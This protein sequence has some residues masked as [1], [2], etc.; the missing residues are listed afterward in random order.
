MRVIVVCCF[1]VIVACGGEKEQPAPQAREGARDAAAPPPPSLAGPLTVDALL[2][3]KRGVKP[4]DEWDAAWA[5]LTRTAGKPTLIEGD[6]HGWYVRS[7][8]ECFALEVVRDPAEA[9]VE[10]VMYGPFGRETSQ[11]ARCGP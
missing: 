1:A 8:E 9:R 2:A 3:A 6:L 7:G 4:F 10:S 5:H 11:F